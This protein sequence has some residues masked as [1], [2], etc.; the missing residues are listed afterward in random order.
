MTT[1]VGIQGYGWSVIGAESVVIADSKVVMLPKN[2]GKVFAT[3]DYVIGIAGVWRVMQVL[4]HTVA[5][6]KPPVKPTINDLDR[7]VT[8]EIVPAIQEG[9]VEARLTMDAEDSWSALISVAGTIFVVDTHYTVTRDKRGL[10]AEGSGGVYALGAMA[11]V[12]YPA[13]IA[14]AKDL[15]KKAISVACQ[16][17]QGSGEPI[18]IY[19][20]TGE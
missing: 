19:S 17:D 18:V 13:T 5:W 4:Q 8:Q 6:P 12:D 15:V 10:Y 14:K 16:Y 9:F 2:T 20:Q 11:M 3:S 7:F 1:L